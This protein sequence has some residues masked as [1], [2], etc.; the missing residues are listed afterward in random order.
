[1]KKI[2]LLAAFF[3]AAVSM[4]AQTT[5][6]SSDSNTTTV[7]I[8]QDANR[9]PVVITQS[10]TQTIEAGAEIACAGASFRNNNMF[11]DF[12]LVGDHGITD[13]LAVNAVEVAI[14][15][16]TTPAGFP[17]TVNIYSTTD[18]FPPNA[19]TLQGTG[20]VIITD[21]NA[22]SFV[23]IPV[24]AVI[25]A[26]ERLIMEIVIV[27]DGTDTNFMRF[28]CN[29]DGELGPSYIQAADCGAVDIASFADLG[30]TQGLVWNILGDDALSVNDNLLSEV[31]VYPNPASDVINV[32]VPSGLEI[33]NVTV[34]DLLGKDTGLRISNGQINI[35]ELSRGVYMLN[36]QTTAG[37]VTEKIVKR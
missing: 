32:R 25:P 4:Q 26:G 10:T 2:T 34:Y 19:G 13:G 24:A 17:M 11:R 6:T 30:L 27:D 9:A 14:G 29:N 36:I 28:G 33:Q 18:A 8:E 20:M 37:N 21:A 5:L 31:S 23:T 16:V 7:T 22:E 1:M 15:P 35:N 3:I 12:D